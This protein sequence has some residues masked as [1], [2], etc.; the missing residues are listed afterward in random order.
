MKD[1]WI[2][3]SSRG[4]HLKM[5]HPVKPG[6]IIFPDHGSREIGKGPEKKILKIAGLKR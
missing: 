6:M 4:S 5:T 3:I 2:V 1:G